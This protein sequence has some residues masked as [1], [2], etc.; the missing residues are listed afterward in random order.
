M[1]ILMMI[2]LLQCGTGQAAWLGMRMRMGRQP[3]N[4]AYMQDISMGWVGD[5]FEG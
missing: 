4:N 5:R 1:M 3:H 2:R